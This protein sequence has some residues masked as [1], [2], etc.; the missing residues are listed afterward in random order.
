MKKT[1][2]LLVKKN[3]DWELTSAVNRK[4]VEGWKL[5][6]SPQIVFRN[7]YKGFYQAMTKTIASTR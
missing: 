2:F 4:L 1:E 3:S 6:G 7:D 5:Q